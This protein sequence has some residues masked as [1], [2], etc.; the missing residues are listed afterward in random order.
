[1]KERYENL[2]GL[3]TI[4]C[5]CLIVMHIQANA[6]F[7]IPSSLQSFMASWTHFVLLFLM[8]S[9]FGMFCGY[10]ERFKEGSINLNTFYI[11]R[12]KKTCP[13][14]ITLILIDI[15]MTRTLNHLIEGI[16]EATMVFGLLPN[17]QLD[18][19]GV[20]WTLGVIFLFYLLFPFFVFMFWTKQKAWFS[21]LTCTVVAVFCTLYFFSE[22]FVVEIFTARHNFLYCAPFFAGGAMVYMYR[23]TIKKIITKYRWPYLIICIGAS[24]FCFS[25][26]NKGR[27]A[28]LFILLRYLPLFMMWI[29]YSISVESKIL[30]NRFVK[31][32]SGISFE[33]YLAHM[34]IFRV[35]EKTQVIYLI[36]NGISS[37]LLTCFIVVFG[38]IVFIPIWRLIYKKIE[39]FIY[40]KVHI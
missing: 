38:L 35:V 28:D 23:D 8:I 20:S 19:I 36:G 26:P 7:N 21:F 24:V 33:M 17:N 30:S 32:I 10:Y 27:Y 3:R 22:R 13:F 40:S 1:M 29:M 34:F 11:K 4:S 39:S 16:T 5:L 9:G 37:L 6:S 2:D 25:L 15:F 14:F 12:Y 31:Y 18:V